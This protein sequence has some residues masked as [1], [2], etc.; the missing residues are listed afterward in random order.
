MPVHDERSGIHGRE[1]LAAKAY[2]QRVVPEP[3][4]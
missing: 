3:Q 1:L 2:G 4:A